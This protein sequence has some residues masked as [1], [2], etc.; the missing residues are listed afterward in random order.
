ML[1][2]GA[3]SNRP[4][5]RRPCGF[6]YTALQKCVRV[7]IK[8]PINVGGGFAG[9]FLKRNRL[10][11]LATGWATGAGFVIAFAFGRVNG[12]GGGGWDVPG[13]RRNG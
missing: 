10:V 1:V 7:P 13:A 6:R 4:V 11:V 5:S 12:A 8:F 2:C 3:H 9:S